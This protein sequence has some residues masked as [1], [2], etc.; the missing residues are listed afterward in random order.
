MAYKIGNQG[1]TLGRLA[2]ALLLAP[3][4]I[5]IHLLKFVKFGFAAKSQLEMLQKKFFYLN[6]FR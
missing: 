4:A 2:K 5:P 6:H 3:V 1:E